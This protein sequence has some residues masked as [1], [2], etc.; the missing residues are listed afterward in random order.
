MTSSNSGSLYRQ[1]GTKG[2]ECQYFFLIYSSAETIDIHQPDVTCLFDQVKILLAVNISLCHH[3]YTRI[4]QWFQLIYSYLE[5]KP[6]GYDGWNWRWVLYQQGTTNG[7]VENNVNV[8]HCSKVLASDRIEKF[9]GD[10]NR[11]C[12]WQRSFVRWRRSRRTRIT[13]GTLRRADCAA[14]R[15][16]RNVWTMGLNRLCNSSLSLFIQ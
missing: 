7:R 13:N 12:R 14:A 10:V 15:I 6:F 8:E 2:I 11:R 4:V 9:T 16:S 1:T 5:W 3:R